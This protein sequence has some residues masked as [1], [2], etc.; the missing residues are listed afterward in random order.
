MENQAPNTAKNIQQSMDEEANGKSGTSLAED[1]AI[2]K[3]TTNV[4]DQP[5]LT[6][7]RDSESD[8][9]GGARQTDQ[10]DKLKE[11]AEK[12]GDGN[13][14]PQV[15]HLEVNDGTKPDSTI[16]LESQQSDH[17]SESTEE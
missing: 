6:P 7:V 9:I 14:T 16:T 4:E 1:T 5:S 12:H 2:N 15:P 13:Q 8:I 17:L 10:L 3:E 11:N